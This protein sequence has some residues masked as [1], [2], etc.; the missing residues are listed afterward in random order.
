LVTIEP[1]ALRIEDVHVHYGP[2]HVLHGVTLDVPAGEITAIVGRNGVGKTSLMNAI[3]GLVPA[4][5]G[6]VWV[7]S[8]DLLD[9][10]AHQRLSLGL[11]I[12]PQGRRLF[13]SLTV[14]EHLNLVKIRR[15][16][17]FNVGTVFELFPP[18]RDRRTV[19]ARNLSGGEQSMLSMAR[20]L[21]TNP[22]ILLLD[23]PTEGLAPLLVDA[24]KDVLLQL[25]ETNLS[26]LL[27][28]QKLSFALSV[29]NRIAIMDRGEITRV[30]K[31]GEID[32]VDLLSRLILGQGD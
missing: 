8:T 25:S 26:V 14:E 2:S 1:P 10:P 30:F 4:T 17:R 16:G 6:H 21:V 29:A 24:I 31:S 5:E 3:M 20:A 12:A 13:H 9:L 11:A 7:R 23:E 28:E 27:V 18:L 22:A 15:S 32:N 19:L